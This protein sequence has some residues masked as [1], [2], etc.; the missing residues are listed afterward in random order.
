MQLDEDLQLDE[1]L[2]LDVLAAAADGNPGR[3]LASLRNG[4][5]KPIHPGQRAAAAARAMGGALRGFNVRK[6]TAVLAAAAFV[7]VAVAIGVLLSSRHSE[8][9]KPGTVEITLPT[10][11]AEA[12]APPP[13]DAPLAVAEAPPGAIDES[14]PVEEPAAA[15]PLV[16]AEVPA[17]PAQTVPEADLLQADT[18]AQEAAPAPTVETTPAPVETAAAPPPVEPAPPVAPKP[19]A[20][21]ASETRTKTAPSP[22]V[23]DAASA[24]KRLPK[25]LAAKREAADDKPFYS[26]SWIKRQK[27]QS[28][29]VQV[30]GSRDRAATTR[31]IRDHRLGEKATVVEQKLKG[32]PWYVVV[33]GLYTTRSAAS[34]AIRAM[35]PALAKQKP[36]PRAVSTLK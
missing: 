34:A 6:Y 31:F 26:S 10:P 2:D 23:A 19:K 1:G 33:T 8:N 20:K 7:L 11:S 14:L 25:P 21:P 28:F 36:W 3:M 4:G 15:A 9:S 27:P 17:E 32:A 35:P 22:S 24:T 5:H 30:F 16:A 13:D 12:P 18:P 29:V